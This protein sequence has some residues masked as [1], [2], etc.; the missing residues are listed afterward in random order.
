MK[1]E[2][3]IPLNRQFSLVTKND[4]GVE[5]EDFYYSYGRSD[6]KGWDK[7]DDEFR[8][9]ILAEAGAGKTEELRN[10][11]TFLSSEGRIGELVSKLNFA[12]TLRL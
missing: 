4:K 6:T 1:N 11:A 7:L 3:Y 10:R 9:V 5:N 12:A 2:E 8:S